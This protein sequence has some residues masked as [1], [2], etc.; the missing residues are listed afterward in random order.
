MQQQADKQ[1]ALDRHYEII[2]RILLQISAGGLTRVDVNNTNVVEIFG[3][4][5]DPSNQIEEYRDVFEWMFNEGVLTR[6]PRPGR[7]PPPGAFSFKDVQL[8]SKGLAIIGT[9]PTGSSDLTASIKN[10]SDEKPSPSYF[11]KIG[12]FVGGVL[13]GWQKTLG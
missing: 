11:S 12:E 7:E 2:G 13:G 1:S 8:T 4:L 3:S 5:S 10:T 9:E 6:R